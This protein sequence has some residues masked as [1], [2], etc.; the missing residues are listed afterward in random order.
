MPDDA[1]PPPD[2]SREPWRYDF[3]RAVRLLECAHPERP[4]IGESMHPKDDPVRFG[5]DPSMAFAPATISG[6][7][8]M[9][10]F[11]R[12]ERL[13]ISFFGLFGPN[14][15]LPLHLTEHARDRQR[16]ARDATM[17]R[18]CD[19]FHHRMTSLF[20][21]AWADAQKSVDFDRPA[22]SRFAAYFGSFFG[23]GM[24]SLR[25]RDDAP[26]V[27]KIYF[28][29]RLSSQP[30]N[31]EG[32]EAIIAEDFGVPTKLLTFVGQWLRLPPE[33]RCKLGASAES[34]TLGR[35]AIVGERFYSGQLKFRLRLGALSLKDYMR[36]LPTGSAWRRLIAWVRNY[37]GRE[38]AWEAQ[39]VLKAAEVP[40][41]TLGK[42]GMLGWNCWLKSK[43]FTR[44]AGDLVLTGDP[45]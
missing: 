25:N 30:R 20:Y 11:G 45:G 38:F 28:A 7:E 21:R 12:P 13:L 10:G 18:F 36:L 41:I 26:D 16:N 1:T 19:T 31:P 8:P 2:F 9:S 39:L 14:G 3:Y 27:T 22:T 4:R 34:G 5:Q 43:P 35:T 23:M 17:V 6:R 29:G 42:S 24:E 15:A 32:L 33:S 40:S 44:D 37:T